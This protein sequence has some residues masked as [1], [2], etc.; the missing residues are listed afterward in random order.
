MKVKKL[1]KKIII[2]NG[3]LLTG[4]LPIV[5]LNNNLVMKNPINDNSLELNISD[6]E[7]N[8]ISNIDFR[9]Y[10]NKENKIYITEESKF[11]IAKKIIYYMLNNENDYFSDAVSSTT[12]DVKKY[13]NNNPN[14]CLLYTSPSPRD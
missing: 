14:T 8:K 9:Y 1:F 6:N 12:Q 3:T 7:I 11:K 13:F 10:Q 4:C 5:G 2:T